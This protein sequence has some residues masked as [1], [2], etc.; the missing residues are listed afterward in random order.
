MEGDPDA[1]PDEYERGEDPQ[2]ERGLADGQPPWELRAIE[3][4]T[5][6]PENTS[7][8][9]ALCHLSADCLGGIVRGPTCGVEVR[10]RLAGA[11][12]HHS[13]VSPVV[14]DPIPARPGVGGERP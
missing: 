2:E 14:W 5:R 6:S 4:E 9:V 1:G 3:E 11:V 7:V 10:V 8:S 13:S 12:G